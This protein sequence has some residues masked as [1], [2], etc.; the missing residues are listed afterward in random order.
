MNWR[1]LLSAEVF[2]GVILTVNT[3]LF[4]GILAMESE[5]LC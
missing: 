4:I 1:R 3:L 5:H 2:Y